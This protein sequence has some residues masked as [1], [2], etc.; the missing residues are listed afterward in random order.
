MGGLRGPYRHMLARVFKAADDYAIK[1]KLFPATSLR[2]WAIAEER[3][4]K[5]AEGAP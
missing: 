1:N 2:V 3:L 5:L 4:K